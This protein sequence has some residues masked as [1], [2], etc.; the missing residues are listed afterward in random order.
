[1][2]NRKKK[3]IPRTLRLQVFDRDNYTCRYCGQPAANPH[4]DHV[5]P[6]SRGGATELGNLVTACRKC[7]MTKRAHLGVWPMPADFQQRIAHLTEHIKEME[8]RALERIKEIEDGN[9]EHIREVE[10]ISR[11]M[12]GRSCAAETRRQEVEQNVMKVDIGTPILAALAAAVLALGLMLFGIESD[13]FTLMVVSMWGMLIAT[14][15]ATTLFVVNRNLERRHM[16]ALGG[17]TRAAHKDR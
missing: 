13:H 8:D 5:Y 6:E 12:E 7:N 15:I 11:Q 1:M 2:T 3:G 4:C 9:L 10:E 16:Q 14:G 17:H